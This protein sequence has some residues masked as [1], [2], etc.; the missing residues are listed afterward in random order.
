MIR[1][2]AISL[3]QLAALIEDEALRQRLD[4]EREHYTKVRDTC[5][6]D[7]TVYRASGGRL[8]LTW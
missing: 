8:G 1:R 4:W 3:E 6:R 5:L 2:P 7:G